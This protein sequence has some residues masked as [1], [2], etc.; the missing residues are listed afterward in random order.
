MVVAISHETINIPVGGKVILRYQTWE[1]YEKLLNLRQEK[2]AIKVVFN[3][4][5]KEIKLM[6]PLPGHGNRVDILSDLV[7]ILLRAKQKEWH[8]FEPITL[9]KF[10]QGGLEP[11]FCF[12]IDNREQILGKERID[13]AIDPPPDLAIEVDLTS[14][15]NIEDYEAIA[16]PE[17][18]IY[19]QKKLL[20]YLF[21]GQKYQQNKESK[22]FTNININLEEILPEYIEKAWNV[23]SSIALREFEEFLTQN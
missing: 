23:G 7:K 13:L 5:T 16:C 2:A 22:I 17:V 6:S 9:K 15:T 11:D 10:P 18:W 12:Y 4:H 8:G 19:R 1:N 21:D 20:I 3:A 14:S